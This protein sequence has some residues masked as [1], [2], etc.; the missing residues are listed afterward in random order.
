M[1]KSVIKIIKTDATLGEGLSYLPMRKNVIAFDIIKKKLFLFDPQKNWQC[2]TYDLPFMGSCA[3]ELRDG[4]VLIAGNQS[5][6]VTEKFEKFTEI[7]S[8]DVGNN[9]RT[10]DGREDPNGNFWYSLM[11]FQ[12]RQNC[13][14]I[15]CFN[16]EK[17]IS[18]EVFKSISIPNSIAFDEKIKC[19]YFSDSHEGVVYKFD[20]ERPADGKSVFIDMSEKKRV[21]DGAVV[22]Q[23]GRLWV[24]QW[25][26][27]CVEV[28]SRAGEL[29]ASVK[30]PVSQPTCP[31]IVNDEYVI[32]TSAKDGLSFW[33]KLK[34]PNAGHTFVLSKKNSII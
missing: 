30:L 10:N 8:H 7:V 12:A 24:A 5:L 26:N 19:G 15:F 31:L 13:G 2:E 21:P 17:M 33:E 20:Y 4:R 29:I 1:K 34:Q 11:D 23:A 3:S 18:R 9:M 22:D 14:S 27:G 28:F 6:Y 16:Q 25:G 32:V